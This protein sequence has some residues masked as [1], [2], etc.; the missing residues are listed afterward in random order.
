MKTIEIADATGP[1]VDY[2]RGSN[3]KPVVLTQDGKPVA[4]LVP[5]KNADLETISLS[6]NPKFLEIIER[7]REQLRQE[8]GIP[9][10]EVERRLGLTK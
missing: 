1:V 8:G 4:V 3:R 2:A 5:V 7:S 9:L 10:E 6:M